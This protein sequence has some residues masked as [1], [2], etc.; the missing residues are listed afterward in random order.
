[1]EAKTIEWISGRSGYIHGCN[2]K[3]L[4]RWLVQGV[5]YQFHHVRA[6]GFTYRVV[7][8]AALENVRIG[9]CPRTPMAQAL[10]MAMAPSCTVPLPNCYER[11]D[12]SATWGRAPVQPPRQ[13]KNPPIQPI[14]PPP[15]VAIAVEN[16]TEE[17][18]PESPKKR[19]R[20]HEEASVQP[21]SPQPTVVYRIENAVF[22]MKTE[23]TM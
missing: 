6:H 1:M 8:S 10:H 18:R 4:E 3:R 2:Q 13:P 5:L 21:T 11:Y 12:P 15:A 23:S 19:Q 16:P 20:K 22:H 9:L 17:P 14:V 7:K